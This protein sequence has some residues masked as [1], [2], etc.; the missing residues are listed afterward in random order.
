VAAIVAAVLLLPSPAL[1]LAGGGGSPSP[2]TAAIVDQLG[3]TQPNPDFSEAATE[4]LEQAGYLVD[5]YPP[6]VVTVEFYRNLPK[7]DYDLIVLRTHS[8]AVI[9]RGEEDV[10]SISLFSNEPYSL[11]LYYDEQLA[12]RIGFAEYQEG[13]PQYFGITAE[14]IRSSMKGKF[15]GATIIMM[16]C[17]GL[18][19]DVAAEA[20]A[21]KGASNFISWDGLVSAEHT[22]EATERLLH[23]L[24]IESQPAAEAVSLTMAEVGPD[25][26][27]GSELLLR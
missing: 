11:D 2:L 26:I 14:F 21:E 12:G 7:G 3:T 23:H 8:T 6:E 17:E 15:D 20:F 16:G 13:G 19:N 18:L 5:Y 1:N 25:P 4:M 10:K 27:H 24:A 22:D 9:S